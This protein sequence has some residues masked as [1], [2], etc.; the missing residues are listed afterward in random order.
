MTTPSYAE[1]K[2]ALLTIL[3]SYPE[4][5]PPSEVYPLLEARFPQ[6]TDDDIQRRQPDGRNGWR[7]TV[8]AVRYQLAESELIDRSV[9]G[10][11]RL[12]A[13]GFSLAQELGAGSQ[14]P[15]PIAPEPDQTNAVAQHMLI[16]LLHEISNAELPW[17]M[18]HLDDGSVA[19]SYD[20]RLRVILRA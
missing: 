19:L 16:A 14:A 20:G 15:E 18:K 12:T 4:G 8:Q 5:L 6:L 11:W 1:L 2:L 17:T 7:N 13:D 10:L 3:A 9:K